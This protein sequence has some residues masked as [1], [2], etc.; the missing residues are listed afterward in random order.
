[1]FSI[2]LVYSLKGEYKRTLKINGFE[3]DMKILNFADESLL[4]YDDVVLEP[5]REN[6]TKKHLTILYQ[7]KR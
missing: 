4:I 2:Y 6:N 1:M 7:K 3:N 5:G